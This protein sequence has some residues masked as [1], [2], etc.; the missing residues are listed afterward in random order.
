VHHELAARAEGDLGASQLRLDEDRPARRRG[1][2]RG[3][4]GLVL[5]AQRQVQDQIEARAQPELLQL[6]LLQLLAL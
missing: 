2:G 5:V 4:R 3:K 1:L 6:L